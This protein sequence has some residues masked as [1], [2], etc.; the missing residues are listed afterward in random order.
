MTSA[1]GARYA[2][3]FAPPPQSALHRFGSRWLGRDAA[4]GACIA[5]PPVAGVTPERLAEITAS[6][7]RY[8]FHATLKAPFRLADGCDE[9][10]LVEA[11]ATLLASREAFMSPS[12][13]LER[14]DGWRALVLAAP[15]PQMQAL[16][17]ELVAGL[18]RFRATPTPA[19]DARRLRDGRLSARQQ[20]LYRRWGY[21]HVFDQ[22]R[23]HMTLTSPLDDAEGTLVDA[24]LA[25]LV[26]PL[27]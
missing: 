2:L 22:F 10:G 9:A 18:D 27:A 6:P 1:T 20:A 5:R 12:L 11:V 3:Y 16:C 8:G 25:P 17:D 15:C 19:E 7:A 23:F 4:S 13:R 14:I 24:A 21:P 26:A